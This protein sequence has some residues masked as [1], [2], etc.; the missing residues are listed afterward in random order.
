M[1]KPLIFIISMLVF[2]GCGLFTGYM[3][4]KIFKCKC[5]K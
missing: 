3:F 1:S 5:K 4:Y 2:Y